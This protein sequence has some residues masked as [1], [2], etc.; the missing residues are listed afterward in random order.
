MR[1]GKSKKQKMNFFECKINIEAMT[2]IKK[3]RIQHQKMK[4]KSLELIF[5]IIIFII[6]FSSFLSS[7]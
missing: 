1:V 3:F 4:K 7:F 5:F 2:N 6:I